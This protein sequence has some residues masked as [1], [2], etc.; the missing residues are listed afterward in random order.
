MFEIITSVLSLIFVEKWCFGYNKFLIK[1][2]Y[3]SGHAEQYWMYKFTCKH[4]N[5]EITKA[6]W[7]IAD[8]QKN[9]LWLNVSAIESVIQLKSRRGFLGQV[10]D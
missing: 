7:N 6:S 5:N 1:I 4:S 10:K 2:V 3:K 8:L 9:A